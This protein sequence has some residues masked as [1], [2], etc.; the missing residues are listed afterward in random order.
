MHPS[1]FASAS[2]NGRIFFWNLATSIDEPVTGANGIA[3]E[4][5]TDPSFSSSAVNKLKWSV[6]GR[7]IAAACSDKLHVLGL[8]EDL[9]KPNGDEDARLMN[10]LKSRGLLDED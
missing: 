10:S 1:V 9:W 4:S 3:I 6:D 8:S 5:E 2:S 7:R